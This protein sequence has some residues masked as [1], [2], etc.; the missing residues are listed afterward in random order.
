MPE[1]SAS[2]ITYSRYAD[3][4]AVSFPHFSTMSILRE[5]LEGYIKDMKIKRSDEELSEDIA[6][7]VERFSRETFIVTDKLDQEYLQEKVQEVK[8]LLKKLPLSKEETYKFV[9]VIDGYKKNIR[10]SGRRIGDVTDEIIK[11]LGEQ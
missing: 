11:I 5:K 8:S 4:V 6:E 3:D 2:K 9:G 1:L 7:I 10:H